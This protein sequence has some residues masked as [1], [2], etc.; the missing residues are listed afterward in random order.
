MRDDKTA[1]GR[2]DNLL[3]GIVGFAGRALT[4]FRLG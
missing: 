4:S 3:G 2:A 1:L